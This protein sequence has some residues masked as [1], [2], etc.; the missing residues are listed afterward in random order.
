MKST[1]IYLVDFV[2][3]IFDCFTHM[4]S[5]R[6]CCLVLSHEDLNIDFSSNNFQD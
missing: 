3:N 5:L 1:E 2:E 6:H 4:D